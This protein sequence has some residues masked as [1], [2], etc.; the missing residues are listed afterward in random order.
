MIGPAYMRPAVARALLDLSR[1]R[2]AHRV[3]VRDYYGNPNR[4]SYAAMVKAAGNYARAVVS[5][6]TTTYP[7]ARSKL[8]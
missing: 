2:R 3:A 7:E 4:T 5:L 1:A 6:T 8:A